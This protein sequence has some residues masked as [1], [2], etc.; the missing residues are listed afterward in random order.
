[1]F[2]KEENG[3]LSR[4]FLTQPTDRYYAKDRSGKLEQLEIPDLTAIYK[5]IFGSK[6]KGGKS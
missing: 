4:Y 2:T 3:E 6:K 1:M 5:K